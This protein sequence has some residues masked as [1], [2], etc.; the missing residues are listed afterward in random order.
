V[1]IYFF[2]FF[3]YKKT[4]VKKKQTK[5]QYRSINKHILLYI[6]TYMYAYTNQY[7]QTNWFLPCCECT[8]AICQSHVSYKYICL[9]VHVSYGGQDGGRGGESAI[10][11]VGEAH[12]WRRRHHRDR[13]QAWPQ[14]KGRR[15]LCECLWRNQ[16]HYRYCDRLSSGTLARGPH[17]SAR[18]ENGISI[19][20]V[21]VR[22]DIGIPVDIVEQR[23][24]ALAKVLLYDRTWSVSEGHTKQ[25]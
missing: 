15:F 23:V 14:K 8:H 4:Y 12:R 9:Y 17:D 25:M 1:F 2:S 20:N 10:R 7:I 6:Y 3:C 11:L 19:N 18:Q 5:T 22:T 13:G 21:G 16:I 24:N